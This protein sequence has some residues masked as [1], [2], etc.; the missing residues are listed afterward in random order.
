M[1]SEF[2][3]A[4]GLITQSL[5]MDNRNAE[6]GFF[7]VLSVEPIYKCLSYHKLLPS[8]QKDRWD[9][10]WNTY[11]NYYVWNERNKNE[12]SQLI[13]LLSLINDGKRIGIGFSSYDNSIYCQ[14]TE[15]IKDALKDGY[16]KIE[17]HEFYC[18]YIYDNNL[19]ELRDIIFNLLLK[20]MQLC[21]E[22]GLVSIND[23]ITPEISRMI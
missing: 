3:F 7:A 13:V 9:D 1:I 16:R 14:L 11:D 18:K 10:F 12:S 2:D 8:S 20:I 5:I 15:I 17:V 4:L 23:E 21:T 6:S 19:T 22:H